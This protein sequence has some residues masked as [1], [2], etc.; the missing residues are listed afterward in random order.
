MSSIGYNQVLAKDAYARY[1]SGN[2][3]ILDVRE[4]EQKSV[5]PQMKQLVSLPMSELP[6]HIAQLPADK[7][8]YVLSGKGRTSALAVS[9]LTASGIQHVKSIHQGIVGWENSGLPTTAFQK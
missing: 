9:L 5:Q 1:I 4:H 2:A 7:A 6:N 3:T 8:I